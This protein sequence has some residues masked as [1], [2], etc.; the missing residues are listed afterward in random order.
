VNTRPVATA[1][2]SAVLATAIAV[3]AERASSLAGGAASARGRGESGRTQVRIGFAVKAL[4]N[5]FF[6]AMYQG[7]RAEAAQRHVRLTVRSVPS[8]FDLAAQAAQVRALLA[9]KEDCYVVNPAAATNLVAALSRA[10]HPIV[11]VDSPIDL[12]AARRVGVRIKTYIGTDDFAAGRI[13]GVRMDALLG[14]RGSVAL[15]AGTPQSVNSGAR[16]AGFEAGIRRSRVR[17]VARATADYD[18]TEAEIAAERIVRAHPQI[19]GFF[20]ANDLMALGI[21]DAVRAAGKAGQ[22]RVIGVDGIPE[23]LDGVRAA[24]I[25]ATVSQYPYV[26]GRMAVEACMAAARGAAL[27]ARVDAPIALI[28]KDNVA[29][30][31]GAFPSPFERYADPFSRLLPG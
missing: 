24:S 29:R 15:I 8:S 5:P 27:P 30:A 22:V 6:V 12:T 2:L 14:G 11:N 1:A 7:A 3:T 23:A 20:A 10:R 16:L 18:R 25:A 28:A 31:A 21:A 26:M 9:G 19:S 17:V 4:D 13:A